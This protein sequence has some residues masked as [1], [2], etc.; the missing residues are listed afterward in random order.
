LSLPHLLLI[1][2]LKL[3]LADSEN[4]LKST[5]PENFSTLISTLADSEITLKST[6]ADSENLLPVNFSNTQDTARASQRGQSGKGDVI[7][8]E[9]I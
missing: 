8:Y 1:S 7:P 2:T 9:D 6:L 4:L 5:L 3:H